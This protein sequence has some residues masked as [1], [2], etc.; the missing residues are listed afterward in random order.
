MGPKLAVAFTK[1]ITKILMISFAIFLKI[2]VAGCSD[3][4]Y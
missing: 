3:V 1:A 2:V 4:Y